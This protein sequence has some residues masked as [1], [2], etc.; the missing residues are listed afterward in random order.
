MDMNISKL[1]ETVADRGAWRAAVHWVA[2]LDTNEQ[3]NK[4]KV[5]LTSTDLLEKTLYEGIIWNWKVWKSV[6]FCP[7]MASQV[8]LGDR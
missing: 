6:C 1:W 4:N 2:E 3:L 7:M 8:D 5:S